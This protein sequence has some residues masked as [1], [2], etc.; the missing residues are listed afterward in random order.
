MPGIA[1]SWSIFGAAPGQAA[2]CPAARRGLA[3]AGWP[4]VR[5]RRAR[6]LEG[7]AWGHRGCGRLSGVS[8]GKASA[9]W[10]AGRSS[11]GRNASVRV[12]VS[13]TQRERATSGTVSIAP[14]GACRPRRPDMRARSPPQ[15]RRQRADVRVEE[16][17]GRYQARAVGLHVRPGGRRRTRR[18]P[19]GCGGASSPPRT[20]M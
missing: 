16:G 17:I 8:T 3:A 9:G 11:G 13:V 7:I 5:Q 20:W 14:A 4:T 19:R 2:S 18:T 10:T 6:H 1:R 15:H 12:G